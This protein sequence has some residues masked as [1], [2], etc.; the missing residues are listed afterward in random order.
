MNFR[1]LEHF[2]R[3]MK[4][5]GLYA[6]LFRNNNNRAIWKE[7]GFEQS[8]EQVNVIFAILLYIMEQSL[9]EE[10]CTMDDIAS[11][12]DE[13][14][15]KYFQKSLTYQECKELCDFIINDVL[16]NKGKAMYFSGYNFMEEEKEALH[17][18]VLQTRIVYLEGDVLRTSYSLSNDGYSMLLA[19]LEVEDNMK[20]TIHE[21]IFKLHLEK[22]TYDKAVEEVK[23]IFNQLRIRLHSMQEAMERIRR[24]ALEYSVKEYREMLEENMKTLNQTS[25]KYDAYRHVVLQR[26]KELEE[27]DINLN[28]LEEKDLENLEY[29]KIIE[30]YLNRAIDELQRLMIAHFEYK[31]LYANEL[32]AIS[33]ISMVKRFSLRA[34]VFEQILDDASRIHSVQEFISPLLNAPLEKT[35][36][37]NRTFLLQ[38]QVEEDKDAQEEIEEFDEAKWE[39]E[40]REKIRVKLEKYQNCVRTILTSAKKKDGLTLRDLKA[41]CEQHP[42]EYKQLI[43]SVEIFKEVVIELLKNKKINL[44]ELKEEQAENIYEIPTEFQLKNS[45]LDLSKEEGLDQIHTVCVT[46]LAGEDPVC[47]EHVSCEDHTRKTIIC[48]NV[49]FECK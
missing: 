1:F 2:E 27:K 4:K 32:E 12:F 34:E 46:K 16:C 14:N 17:V 20:L 23:N 15:M 19:T 5:V 42:E 21:M 47:F 13:L 45:L 29:L 49:M 26:V 35:Y 8:D 3:R 43:P 36:N 44:D 24:N 28:K 38:K 40:R 41:Y 9:K 22:A 33:N 11:Y 7:H 25:E 37:L 31:S 48:S 18:S 39:E 6:V 30:N 10:I